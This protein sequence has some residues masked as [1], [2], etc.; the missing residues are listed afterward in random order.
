M[1]LAV[2]LMEAFQITVDVTTDPDHGQ[3]EGFVLGG[4]AVVANWLRAPGLWYVDAS[5]PP[6]RRAVYRD[7]AAAA[8]SRSIID[9]PT[10][11][12]RLEA[13][14]GYLD[15]SW[16][17][18]RK[19]CTELS[20]VGASGIAQPRSRLLSTMGLD[21]PSATSPASTATKKHDLHAAELTM[22][23]TF[24][25]RFDHGEDFISSLADFCR[26]HDLRQGF[27]PMLIAGLRA[28]ELVGTCAKAD[29]PEAPVW[30][31]VHLESVE[32]LG[33]G[34]LV[35]DPQ[36]QRI[37]PHIHVAVGLKHQSATAYTSHLLGAE[38]QFLTEMYVVEV[39]GPTMSRLHLA[40]LYD[41]P[42]LQF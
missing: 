21:L 11:A 4:E 16:R 2:A 22:G 25:V 15:I 26:Q 3:V 40:D 30:S 1:L 36:A 19:R 18:F 9:Q 29:D 42:Q 24:A 31:S 20:V 13:L 28:V 27:V 34:T 32:A 38:M 10:A 8:T 33:G 6:S 35:Y 7:I 17:W 5:A 23:R 39:A 41:V 14:A 37:L 12:R